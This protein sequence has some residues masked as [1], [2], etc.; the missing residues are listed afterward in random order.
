MEFIVRVDSKGRV[1]IPKGLREA[2]G[3]KEGGLVRVYVEGGRV[4]VE[5]L[6][7]VADR[8]FGCFKVER[9]P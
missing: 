3:V 4:V 6:G 2:V 5:P 1:L 9:W 7:S 8:F